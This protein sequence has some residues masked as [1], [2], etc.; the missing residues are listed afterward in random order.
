MGQEKSM[1]NHDF[2]NLITQLETLFKEGH[3]R[4]ALQK[5]NSRLQDFPEKAAHLNY[6]RMSLAARVG[7]L[8]QSKKILQEALENG[9][10]YSVELLRATNSLSALQ[11]DSE[12]ESLLDI[13]ATMRSADPYENLSLTTIH[14]QDKCK[15]D[16]PPCSLILFLHDNYE[17]AQI[18]IPLWRTAALE[19][20]LVAFPQSTSAMWAGAYVWLDELSAAE[21]IKITIHSLAE[22]YHID[23]NRIIL[24]GIGEGAGMALLLSL[25]RAINACG[26]ILVAPKGELLKSQKK[27]EAV[28]EKNHNPNLRIMVTTSEG[29]K[30]NGQESIERLLKKLKEHGFPYILETYPPSEYP[31]PPNFEEILPLALDFIIKE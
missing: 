8:S 1:I 31:Y 3:Y 17:T 22:R 19:N 18:H 9:T 29:Q 20:W 13:A 28:L 14:P 16:D 2:N 24:S 11:D 15:K 12:Y 5:V 27:L 6:L 30:E 7:D 21:Q 26:V 10:W 23:P 4:A 25:T